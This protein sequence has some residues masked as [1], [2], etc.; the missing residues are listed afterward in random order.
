[1]NLAPQED[2]DS[3]KIHINASILDG[4]M[5]SQ[6][7]G[8]FEYRWPLTFSNKNVAYLRTYAQRFFRFMKF[9]GLPKRGGG[10]L[11]P[12]TPSPLDPSLLP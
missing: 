3:T 10:L 9:R 4:I 2:T 11:T 8:L 7:E 5:K 6:N 1:M 12:K